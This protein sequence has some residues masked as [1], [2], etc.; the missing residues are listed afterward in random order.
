MISKLKIINGFGA[1]V[2]E[3]NIVALK[4]N[5]II[6]F[7]NSETS[8]N[9]SF[10]KDFDNKLWDIIVEIKEEKISIEE[11]IKNIYKILPKT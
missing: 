11:G 6:D 8:H 9:T 2:T 3:H 7:I 5:E 1:D 4:I 10:S